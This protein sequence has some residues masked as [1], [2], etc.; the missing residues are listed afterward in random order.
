MNP[1][2]TDPPAPPPAPA[3]PETAARAGFVALVGAP[4]AGKSTLLNTLVGAKV[5]IVSRKVQTTRARVLGIV[6]AGDAQIIFVDTPGI[7]APKKRL[8]RAMVSAAWQGAEEA[9]LVAVLVDAGARPRGRDAIGR[10]TL[11]DAIGGDTADILARLKAGGRTAVLVLNKVD[12]VEPPTL[13]ALA[14]RLNREGLFT[15][16]FMVSAL[17]GDGVADLKAHFAA[18]MPRGPWLFPADQLSDMPDRLL[19][20]EIVREQLFEQLH[21][22]LPYALTVETEAWEERKDGSVRIDA[23]VYVQ[24][25]SQRAIV[26]GGKGERIKSIGARARKELETLFERRVHLFLFVKVREKWQDDP[27]RYRAM[28]LEWER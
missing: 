5:S 8:D 2:E 14:D 28:G 7:F 13:L 18:A 3:P 19:A 10:G 9:D 1:P 20:A 26:L 11:G 6:A 24:R 17:T 25:D 22:E 21:Q 4:N 12:L 16:T 27:A 23:T 15:D